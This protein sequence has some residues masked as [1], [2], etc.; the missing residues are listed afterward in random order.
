MV[1]SLISTIC[2]LGRCS[3]VLHTSCVPPPEVPKGCGLKGRGQGWTGPKRTK[4][5]RVDSVKSRGNWR[6]VYSGGQGAWRRDQ[7]HY[8]LCVYSRRALSPLLPSHPLLSPAVHHD[9]IHCPR[10]ARRRRLAVAFL[11]QLS[12]LHHHQRNVSQ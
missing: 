12:N 4:V 11:Q 2:S 8:M 3:A 10:T 1:L 5:A 6:Q 9:S 7:C